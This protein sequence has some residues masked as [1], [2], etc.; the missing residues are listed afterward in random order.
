ML[1]E[2]LLMRAAAFHHHQQF[3]THPGFRVVNQPL[4]NPNGTGPGLVPGLGQLVSS[5]QANHHNNMGFP[6]PN[7]LDNTLAGQ[8]HNQDPTNN[9]NFSS[10][11]PLFLPMHT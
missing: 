1:S 3:N 8:L 6:L 7:G 10:I 9:V 5:N 4:M 11:L 2:A